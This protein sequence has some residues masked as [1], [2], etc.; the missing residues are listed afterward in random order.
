MKRNHDNF[1]LNEDNTLIKQSF[2]DVA[3]Q[4]ALNS[5]NSVADVGCATGAF[6]NYLKTRFP[7]SEITGI[8]YLGN[9][10]TEAKKSFPHIRF[11]EG[12]VLEKDSVSEKYD[13]ITMLGVFGIFDDYK[14]ALHNVLS[15]LNPNGRL[16]LQNMISGYDVDVFVKYCP[17]SSDY[18]PDRLESGWNVI[19]EKSLSLVAKENNAEII[20]SKPFQLR[21]NIEKQSDV[22]RSWTEKNMLGGNDIF[23]ALHIRQPQKIVT[24]K[25]Y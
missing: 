23:N 20:S 21:V 10:L 24:I 14:K 11:N 18:K 7:S 12:N 6:P 9:L 5:F 15:W 13:V 17:S 8:E 25:K 22:M 2:V 4:I 1:Y 3:D 16:I 19:S